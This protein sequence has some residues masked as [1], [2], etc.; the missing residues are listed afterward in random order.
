[1]NQITK[2]TPTELHY[3]EKSVF[4]KEVNTQNFWPCELVTQESINV[5]I[6]FY[7]VFQQNDRQRDQNMNN[8]SFY[9]MPVTTAQCFIG[10]EKHPDSDIFLNYNDDD[11]SQGYGKI[12]QAIKALTNDNILQLYI[13]E[14]DFIT[15]IDGDNIGDNIHSSDIQY[16]KNFEAGQS[17]KVEFKLGGVVPARIYGYA[18]VLTNRLV[19]ISSDGQRM[20]HL[21]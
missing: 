8:D 2:K 10:N 18:V 16:Q 12:K 7:V 13:V 21:V 5:L 19:S 9:R 11:Y 15:S 3:P 6:R 1:M 14:D 17:V 20:F 4:M